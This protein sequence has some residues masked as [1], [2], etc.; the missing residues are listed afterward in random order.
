MFVELNVSGTI[1]YTTK[2]TLSKYDCYFKTMLQYQKNSFVID[3]DPTYFRYVLN[4]MRGS[5][6]LPN[7]ICELQQLK[8]EAEFYCIDIL[9]RSIE[10]R[11]EKFKFYNNHPISITLENI[12]NKLQ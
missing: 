9:K 11:M 6:Y 7:D 3:R 8:E 1:F 5:S 2:E 12:L 10:S 4:F